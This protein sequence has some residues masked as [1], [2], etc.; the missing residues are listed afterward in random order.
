[1]TEAT[2]VL[3]GVD[4]SDFSRTS[5]IAVGKLIAGNRGGR[6]GIFH[7]APDPRVIFSK[8]AHLDREDVE[9]HVRRLNLESKHCL[10]RAKSTLI[11]AG[12]EGERI[13]TVLE[14]NCS[15]PA[16]SMIDFAA[17]EGFDAVGLGRFGAS[18]AGRH[19][20]GSISYRVACSSEKVPV[21]IVDHRVH[22]R[23]LLICMVGVPVGQR[24]I[25]HVVNHF[26]HLN[27]SRFTL[28]HVIPP[29]SIQADDITK[30]LSHSSSEVERDR[31]MEDINV[32]LKRTEKAMEEG[33]S[34][35]I[36]AGIPE[37]NIDL[38][39]KAQDQGIARDIL[40]ELESGNNGILVTGRKGSKEIKEFGL[41]SKAYKLLCA[42][43]A[44][45][46]CLVN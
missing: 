22:S 44:F 19:V 31:L 30:F 3:F 28:F 42:A 27:E 5:L 26:T 41:G 32:P 25:D 34:K 1:M 38:K 8:F 16:G 17:S 18:T 39:I 33:K 20:M 14:E 15:D 9:G 36:A 45:M 11:E 29:F 43:G 40:A 21:W 6:I 46:T 24:I 23:N 37:R 7:G 12:I 4:D 10:D 13:S 35:L 2:R